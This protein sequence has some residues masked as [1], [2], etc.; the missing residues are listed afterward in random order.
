[1]STKSKMSTKRAWKLDEFQGHSGMVTCLSLGRKSGRVLATG[2]EDKRVNLWAVGSNKCILSFPGHTHPLEAVRFSSSEELVCGGSQSGAIR[3]WDLTAAKLLRTLTGHRG[4]VRSLDFHPYG[5]F[6]V[7]GSQDNSI[8]LWDVRRKGCIYNYRSH[9]QAVNSV[10]FSPDGQW[11]VSAGEDSAVKIFDIRAGK[12]IS[13]LLEHTSSVTGVE[14]HP[15]EFLLAS[16]ST[17]RRI[18]FWDLETF[19]LVSSS[20][21]SDGPIKNISFHPDGKCLLSGTPEGLRVYTWEPCRVLD[22]V[23]FSWP[24]LVDFATTSSQTQLIGASCHLSNV[25]V[26]VVDLKRVIPIGGPPPDSP[27]SEF[28]HGQ[29][30]RKSFNK[31]RP[32]GGI[33]P[34]IRI[35]ESDKSSSTDAEDDNSSTADLT[36]LTY[37]AVFRTKRDYATP[38]VINP[39]PPDVLPQQRSVAMPVPQVSRNQT[40]TP[41]P[42]TPART[43]PNIVDRSREP[44]RNRAPVRHQRRS[45]LGERQSPPSNAPVASVRGRNRDSVK[46]LVHASQSDNESGRQPYQSPAEPMLS[47]SMGH[48]RSSSLTRGPRQAPD[49]IVSRTRPDVTV[50]SVFGRPKVQTQSRP[51][52]SLSLSVETS[53]LRGMPG[54]RHNIGLNSPLSPI[55]P[56]RNANNFDYISP[57]AD[58]PTGLN[59]LDFVPRRIIDG[60]D[61]SSLSLSC[62]SPDPCEEEAIESIDRG[63]HPVQTSLGS[64]LNSLQAVQTFWSSRDIKVALDTA[65]SMGDQGVIVDVLNVAITKPSIWSLD[66]CTLVLP[67]VS[68]IIQSKYETYVLTASAVLRLILSNFS[69]IIKTNLEAPITSVGV[70]ISREERYN[71]SMSCYTQ[72][73]PVK[74]FVQKRQAVVGKIGQTFRE[75]HLLLQTL[76]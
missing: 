60:L 25:S 6:V 49:I 11:V 17:D 32:P 46:D 76:D 37:T 29:T 40:L 59:M 57:S 1:M 22:F 44:S 54:I 58:R 14:F 28:K 35:E 23:P 74:A 4:G 61:I 42:P 38:I 10:K 9:S 7:S 36:D 52:S 26:Y 2:G 66:L 71:K 51:P 56:F 27:I 31:D 15:H 72:L 50:P 33:S 8:K 64:R 55:E 30:L 69:Q 73:L 75:L 70:D 18:L 12:L 20:D 48:S 21:K 62:D 34:K 68:A 16:A 67:S 45:S 5:D 41:S 3:V 47:R 63:F 53:S 13:E 65:I 39:P 24:R 19:R 43:A